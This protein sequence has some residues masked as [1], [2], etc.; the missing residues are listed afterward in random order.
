MR[1]GKSAAKEF[2]KAKQ[3]LKAARRT[4]SGVDCSVNVGRISTKPQRPKDMTEAWR[5]AVAE[6]VKEANLKPEEVG[7]AE[8]AVAANVSESELWQRITSGSPRDGAWVFTTNGPDS[9]NTG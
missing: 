5:L 2:E 8:K 7:L 1:R 9:Y 6:H 3:A 4:A